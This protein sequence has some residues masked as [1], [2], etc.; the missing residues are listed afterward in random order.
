MKRVALLLTIINSSLVYAYTFPDTTIQS[1]ACQTCDN[2]S[3][4]QL[5]LSWAMNQNVLS[6]PKPH[7]VHSQTYRT[8]LSTAT[9][10]K[11]FVFNTQGQKIRL[12]IVSL[13]K[14]PL[15]NHLINLKQAGETRVL[16]PLSQRHPYQIVDDISLAKHTHQVTL[17]PSLKFKQNGRFRISVTD[18]NSPLSLSVT[19]DKLNYQTG[20]MLQT[21]IAFSD[22]NMNYPI[23]HLKVTLTKP[24]G[25]IFELTPT[26]ES[27]HAYHATFLLNDT[28]NPNGENNYIDITSE[29]TINDDTVK[30]TAHTALSYA[31]PSAT[32]REAYFRQDTNALHFQTDVATDSRYAFKFILFEKNEKGAYDSKR[33]IE[34][35]Q[36]LTK[37][38]HDVTVLLNE[39]SPTKR[40]ALGNITLIDDGQLKPVFHHFPTIPFSEL[41]K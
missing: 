4:K 21:Q 35:S 10:N 26:E 1:Y 19:T 39:I 6:P 36:F 12:S 40:F 8:T 31:I 28:I 2:L 11:G 34:Q 25:E 15:T 5:T 23:T 30:R 3:H 41:I 22:G 16:K 20:D 38:T 24:N 37:G 29:T 13:D 7:P 32:I 9:F 33:Y 17:S 18:I 27:N 14:I